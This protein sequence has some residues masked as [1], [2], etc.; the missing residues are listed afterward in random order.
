MSSLRG[1]RVVFVFNW[2][3]LGG[4]EQNALGLAEHLRSSEGAHVHVVA[5]TDRDGLARRR[6]AGLGIGWDAGEVAWDGSRS[7][8]AHALGRLARRL[9]RARPDVL[10]PYTTVPNVLCGLVWRL[11]GAEACI[12]NQRDV[13]PSRRFSSSLVRR[14]LRA[15]P[16]AIGNSEAAREFLVAAWDARADRTHV[17]V[18]GIDAP[19]ARS[20]RASWRRLLGVADER[21]VAVMLGHLH[22]FKDHDTLLR[23]WRFLLDRWQPDVPTPL[24]VLAGRPSRTEKEVKAL[25]FDLELGESVRFL[26]TVDDVGGLLAGSDIGV[27]SSRRESRPRAVLEYMACGLPVAGTDIRGIREAVGPEGLRFLAPAGDAEALAAVLAQLAGDAGLR[28]EAGAAS[29]SRFEGFPSPQESRARTAALI[30]KALE[31]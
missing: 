15:T 19:T 4:A 12:W 6:F 9:R 3:D 2:A 31:A 29:A 24:L 23:A 16:L 27:L 21:S 18:D 1:R 22:A 5:L 13:N 30:A 28:R 11:T 7:A 20:D 26:G 8:K 17:V 14:A 25:A 10:M